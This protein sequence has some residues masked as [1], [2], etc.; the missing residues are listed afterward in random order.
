MDNR[1]CLCC[2][3]LSAKPLVVRTYGM[4]MGSSLSNYN[5]WWVH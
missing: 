5:G 4:A 2:R 3:L 1:H